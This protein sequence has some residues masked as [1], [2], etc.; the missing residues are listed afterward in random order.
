MLVLNSSPGSLPVP[1]EAIMNRPIIPQT[2]APTFLL[3]PVLI[4]SSP[5]DLV[6]R[7]QDIRLRQQRSHITD[8]ENL[9]FE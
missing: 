4:P 6:C 3:M 7:M 9:Y 5:P 2:N 8:N 1:V